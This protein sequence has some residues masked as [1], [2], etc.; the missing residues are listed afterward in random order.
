LIDRSD[1][2]ELKLNKSKFIS[3][4]NARYYQVSQKRLLL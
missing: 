1:D 4:R 2:I 3:E